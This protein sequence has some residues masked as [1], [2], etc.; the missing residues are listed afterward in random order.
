M[1]PTT[2]ADVFEAGLAALEA[3]ATRTSARGRFI[4]L[5][6]A[7][8]R[9]GAGLQALGGPGATPPSELEQFL[10]TLYTK[11]HQAEPY[12]VLT[13]P[14][15]GST[16]PSA[17]YSTRTGQ[18]APGNSYPTNTWRN[19]FGVQKGVGCPA[20]P[21]VIA[22]LL[23]TPGIR[24]AC[25]H[26][27]VDTE[28]RHGCGITGTAYRG[29]EHSIW[30][31]I[32]E[33]GYQVAPLDDPAVCAAYLLPAGE[34]I[35][36]FALIAVLYSFASPTAYPLRSTVGIPEFAADF[37]FALDQVQSLFDCDPDSPGNAAIL[38]AIHDGAG[39]AMSVIDAMTPTTA[40]A[41]VIP[42]AAGPLPALGP[43]GQINDGVGAELAVAAD[44]DRCGW[45]VAY[46]GNQ[47]TAGYDLEAQRETQTLRVEVKSSIGFTT[48]E[49]S[50]QEWTAAQRFGEEFVLAVVDFYGSPAQSIWYVRNLAL[51]A[52]PVE[53]PMIVYRLQRVEIQPLKTDADFL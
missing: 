33:N 47:R 1:I 32:T 39:A 40:L 3:F 38:G 31:R 26:M 52:T 45:R 11:T 41:A 20:E 28:G 24:L 21:E 53:K 16:S 5:Y 2:R 23:A 6:L 49:L 50:E 35:P 44:L 37:H 48:P 10:D 42:L 18:T 12:V 17:P 19:N 30:L 13:A 14:F 36:V 25:P 29:E 8:R 46:R 34:R 51:T 4:A 43:L 7:L 27:S 15:G 9:M 22:G